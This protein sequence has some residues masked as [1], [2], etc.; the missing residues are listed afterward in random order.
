MKENAIDTKNFDELLLLQ[1]QILKIKCNINNEEATKH[2][3][4]TPFIQ[5][6]GFNI[7]NPNE[8]KPEYFAD[9]SIK[10]GE[11]VDY[12]LC[13]ENSPIIFLEAKSVNEDLTKHFSQISRYFNSTPTVKV[14]ILT[15]G[16]QYKF[17][18][19]LQNDNI[20]DE[21]PFFEFDFN[22]ID[23][24][25]KNMV[26]MFY[27]TSFDIQKIKSFAY[28]RYLTLSINNKLKD[29]LKN[30]SDDFIRFLTK[31]ITKTKITSASLNK[32]RPITDISIKTLIENIRQNENVSDDIS[33]DTAN[34]VITTT[35]E[36]IKAYGYINTIL[37]KANK[38]TENI[39]FKDT[40]SYFSINIY[41][42]KKWFVRLLFDRQPKF[43]LINLP[44]NEE[45][46]SLCGNFK[47][48]SIDS[49]NIT[50]IYIDD[51]NDLFS[52]S[53]VIIKVFETLE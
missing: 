27:K 3:L 12:A 6:L 26:S 34:K 15:N 39:C 48:Q 17:F 31:D 30:P 47:S 28:E 24:E 43:I 38:N 18:T 46:K 1:E 49:K 50:K 10:K 19:D 2:S 25:T 23:D 42:I 29:L 21:V 8:V 44:Y 9:F 36:E 35:I 40:A 13:I 4:I 20:M 14:G 53:K 33:E 52:L 5:F 16:I 45:I 37:A 32:L 51:I 22:N 41:N 7:H 11:K